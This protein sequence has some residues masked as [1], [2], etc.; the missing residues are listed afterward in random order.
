MSEQTSSLEQQAE[1]ENMLFRET[2]YVLR[3]MVEY[4]PII[5][6]PLMNREMNLI[7]R[8]IKILNEWIKHTHVHQ[9]PRL[10][11]LYQD[12]IVRDC[13]KLL[14]TKT[15]N[16][17]NGALNYSGGGDIRRCRPLNS[18]VSCRTASTNLTT[19]LQR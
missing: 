1:E 13:L 12:Q 14:R 19:N 18:R 16:Y 11:H 2:R 10:K 6:S 7:Q 4:D 8:G 5:D 15:G 9:K 17:P 3:K